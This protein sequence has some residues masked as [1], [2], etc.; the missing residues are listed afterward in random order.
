[1]IRAAFVAG[2]VVA[3]A[4]A[5]AGSPGPMMRGDDGSVHAGAGSSVAHHSLGS[6]VTYSRLVV[7]RFRTRAGGLLTVTVR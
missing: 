7:Y 4:L 5:V 2:I 1:M 3:A 6:I